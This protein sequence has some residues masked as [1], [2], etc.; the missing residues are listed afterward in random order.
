MYIHIKMDINVF[1]MLSQS[2][3]LGNDFRMLQSFVDF[4]E[5]FIFLLLGITIFHTSQTDITPAT[6]YEGF[7][8]T[9][10]I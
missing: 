3:N 1:D 9:C 8:L 2:S 10:I 4:I 7:T 5:N 6:Y